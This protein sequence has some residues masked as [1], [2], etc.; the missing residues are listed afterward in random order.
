[1]K[2]MNFGFI[3]LILYNKNTDQLQLFF[4]YTVEKNVVINASDYMLE[5]TSHNIFTQRIIPFLYNDISRVS[6]I[7]KECLFAYKKC[8][9]PIEM[10]KM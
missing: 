3:C 6:F 1:M 8:K 5:I 9:W 7:Y 4:S 2:I 10:T